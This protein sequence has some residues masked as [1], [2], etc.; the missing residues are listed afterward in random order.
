M[1]RLVL[2]L[3]SALSTFFVFKHF[4]QLISDS[5]VVL[6]RHAAKF[7]S[8]MCAIFYFCSSLFIA[9]YLLNQIAY[10]QKQCW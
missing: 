9:L 5:L 1:L 3:S 4:V 2:I 8:D 6:F 10:E 7:T